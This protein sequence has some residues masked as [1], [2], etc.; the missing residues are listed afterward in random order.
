MPAH[1]AFHPTPPSIH[2]IR[3][4]LTAAFL[5]LCG[6]SAVG[7]TARAEETRVVVRVLAKDAKFIG[8]SIGGALVTIKDADTGELLASGRTQG[9]TGDTRR[10]MKEPRTRGEA[11]AVEGSAAFTATLDLDRPR[12]VE[13]T[14]YGPQ[15]QRQAANRVSATQWLVPGKHIEAGDAFLLIMPGFA[16]DALAPA[17][18]SVWPGLP[19]Q[20]H[21]EANVVMMCGCP[22]TPGGLWDADRY[23][24]TAVVS[25]EGETAAKV[26][27]EYA[28]ITSRF[29]GE[30]TA[31]EPGVYTV[32]IYAY[33]P[34]NGNTGVDRTSFIVVPKE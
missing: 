3:R 24:V 22:I 13:I 20:I 10:I 1:R 11:L 2:S 8:S 6:L 31:T 32:L 9:T 12:W 15:G 21:L 5:L 14:A 27:L 19:Q 17:A 4:L 28:G 34:A 33:D 26:P 16:V 30:F 18:H 29:S 7:G 25:K 23:E